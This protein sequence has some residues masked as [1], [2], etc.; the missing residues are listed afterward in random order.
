M[1]VIGARFRNRRLPLPR[2]TGY[3]AIRYSSITPRSM[4]AFTSSA[5]PETKMSPPGPS[6][7][8]RTSSM[9]SPLN[10][11]AFAQSTRLSVLETTYFG[12]A[13]MRSANPSSRGADGQND[14]QI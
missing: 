6:L 5:L 1:Y 7:R 3:T 12:I 10:S 2:A 9:A 11:V 8:R 14:A 4:S 13:L